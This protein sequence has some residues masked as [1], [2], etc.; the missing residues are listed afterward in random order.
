MKSY[1]ISPMVSLTKMK[2]MNPVYAVA[3]WLLNVLGSWFA[4][5]HDLTDWAQIGWSFAGATVYV[6][7]E[8]VGKVARPGLHRFYLIIIG[9]VT[10]LALNKAVIERWDTEAHA[11]TFCIALFFY[12]L[13]GPLKDLL[14]KYVTSKAPAP[15]PPTDNPPVL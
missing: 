4:T 9:M 11:T 5:V 12:S 10:S 15:T 14:V 2:R 6:L 7:I 1:R 13:F 3:G 8:I